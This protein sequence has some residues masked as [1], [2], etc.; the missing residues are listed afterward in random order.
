[1]RG[2]RAVLGMGAAFAALCAFGL[3]LTRAEPASEPEPPALPKLPAPPAPQA[4]PSRHAAPG[5]PA[6]PSVAP[7][8][9]IASATPVATVAPAAPVRTAALPV[10][11][12]PEP[13]RPLTGAR[14][15]TPEPRAEDET[16]TLDKE[17]IR[18]A[19]KGVEPLIKDCFLD[20]A[21]RNPGDQKVV[22]R[23]TIV[24]QGTSGHFDEGE[25]VESTIVDP[26]VQACFLDSLTDAQFRP[27]H[28]K[29]KVTVTYPFKFTAHPKDGG[30]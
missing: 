16:A 11:R 9:P 17:D 7:A 21:E 8:A 15:E 3:W 5:S 6:A 13:L 1:M 24:G 2:S 29:G 19:I 27:P 23:F 12:W 18:A 10:E 20:A 4:G 25:V 14:V 28:G 22:L 26:W 30:T